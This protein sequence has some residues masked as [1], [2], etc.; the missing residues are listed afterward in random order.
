MSNENNEWF[1]NKYGR[2]RLQVRTKFNHRTMHIQGIGPL[3]VNRE[4]G[5][6]IDL[7]TPDEVVDWLAEQ[8]PKQKSAASGDDLYIELIV[9][10]YPSVDEDEPYQFYIVGDYKLNWGEG[11]ILDCNTKSFPVMSVIDFANQ[12]GLVRE[13]EGTPINTNSGDKDE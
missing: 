3:E 1:E 13:C 5:L 9:R 10:K 11:A 4:Y 2:T 7:R 6:S 8:A 12:C